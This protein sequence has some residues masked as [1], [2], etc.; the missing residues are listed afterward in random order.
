[1]MT[2]NLKREMAGVVKAMV[3]N[4]APSLQDK[5]S[6]GACIYATAIGYALLRKAKVNVLIQ[7][8]SM[9]W[10]LRADGIDDGIGDTHFSYMWECEDN[11][12]KALRDILR[13]TLP[14]MHAWLAIPDTQEVIDF[15][16]FKTRE[17]AG[18]SV[19][20]TS[21]MM[22]PDYLWCPFTEMPDG[23]HYRAYPGACLLAHHI[24][25]SAAEEMAGRVA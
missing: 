5:T 6:G 19:V 18:L 7:G 21:H 11:P 17:H 1:M 25:M 2:D 9:S 3:L 24:C 15:S 4:L 10:P 23:A 22:M 13:G 16:L 20:D 12:A 8:G 14:E